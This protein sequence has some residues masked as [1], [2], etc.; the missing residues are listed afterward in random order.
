ML[1]IKSY[2]SSRIFKTIAEFLQSLNFDKNAILIVPLNGEIHGR[3]A[4]SRRHLLFY[5]EPLSDPPSLIPPPALSST[6]IWTFSSWSYSLIKNY[7]APETKIKTR[8][9]WKFSS[10]YIGAWSLM[11]LI[12]HLSELR[13]CLWVMCFLKYIFGSAYVGR[14]DCMSRPS[15]IPGQY[16]FYH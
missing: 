4:T 3:H 10:L 8:S 14:Y 16:P 13:L 15:K 11:H 5:L 2:I 1:I 12:T 6:I 9:L 7:D